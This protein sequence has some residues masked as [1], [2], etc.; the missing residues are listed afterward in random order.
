MCT[1]RVSFSDILRSSENSSQA[2]SQNPG[3]VHSFSWA[4]RSRYDWSVW[5]NERG[6]GILKLSMFVF[7]WPAK[8]WS[9]RKKL[10]LGVLGGDEALDFGA[11][12]ED[13]DWALLFESA[14]TGQPVEAMVVPLPGAAGMYSGGQKSWDNLLK[15]VPVHIFPNSRYP[16]CTDSYSLIAYRMFG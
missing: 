10:K 13:S 16:A 6:I 11:T 4:V 8:L 1:S 2:D 14:K 3:G 7:S 12:E 15:I 5:L 9:F